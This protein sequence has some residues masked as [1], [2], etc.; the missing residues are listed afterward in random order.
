MSAGTFIAVLPLAVVE[1]P[2]SLKDGITRYTER[3]YR[4]FGTGLIAEMCVLLRLPQVVAATAQALFHR[5]YYRKSFAQ[6][7]AHVVAMTAVFL[8]AKVE[9]EPRRIRDVI[10]VCYRLKLRRQ[11]KVARPITLGGHVSATSRGGATGREA[12][13]KEGPLRAPFTLI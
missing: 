1:A 3:L 4:L 8:G 10:N 6:F 13:V 11:R 9:E 7:D 2:P 12:C 5:L